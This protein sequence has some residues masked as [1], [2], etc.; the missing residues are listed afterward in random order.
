MGIL[1]LHERNTFKSR[2]RIREPH[3]VKSQFST[4]LNIKQSKQAKAF[5]KIDIQRRM[6]NSYVSYESIL[7][8]YP[9]YF[10]VKFI[11]RRPLSV[12]S[13]SLLRVIALR[14][15]TL[16]S[17]Y[18]LVATSCYQLASQLLLAISRMTF[19]IFILRAQAWWPA[20]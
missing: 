18:Q 1:R 11:R 19:F 2:F 7:S 13:F 16:A 12:V 20:G 8:V 10:A 3:C 9:L 6:D 15:P 14:V 4:K 5:R 17:Y